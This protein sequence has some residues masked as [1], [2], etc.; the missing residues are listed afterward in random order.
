MKNANTGIVKI[1]VTYNQVGLKEEEHI[2]IQ[3]KP[4]SGFPTTTTGTPVSTFAAVT[5]QDRMCCFHHF[6]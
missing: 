2:A 4:K 3:V 1:R 5:K 6:P